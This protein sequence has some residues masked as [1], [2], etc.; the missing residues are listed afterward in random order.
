MTYQKPTYVDSSPRIAEPEFNQTTEYE[1]VIYNYFLDLV[2][3]DSSQIVVEKFKN[4]FLYFINDEESNSEALNALFRV[5][6]ENDEEKFHKLLNRCC[7]ILVNNWQSAR[8]Y[9]AIQNLIQ[10]FED[11]TLDYE[12]TSMSLER[13]R[14]WVKNFSQSQD[15]KELK[16]FTSR[17]DDGPWSHRY[18]S[19]LLTHQ[20]I[21]GKSKEQQEAARALSQQI[22]E[23]FKFD[24]AMYTAR[25]KSGGGDRT[26][27]TPTENPTQLGEDVLRLIKTVVTKRGAFS[28]INFANIFVNQTE[29]VSYKAFK[30]ALKKY[31]IFSV[32]H[33]GFVK[34]LNTQLSAK[35]NDLNTESESETLTEPLKQN[36]CQKV[37]EY[38][39]TEN[40]QE[41]SLLFVLLLNN[42]NPLTLAI[43]LLKIV[44]ICEKS[45]PH[46]EA[47]LASLIRYYEERT[48]SEC[49]WFIYFLEV[50]RITF[51]IY[52]DNVEY[53]VVKLDKPSCNNPSD[54]DE[55]E[56]RIFSFVKKRLQEKI[57]LMENGSNSNA[58]EENLPAESGNLA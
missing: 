51:A 12:T 28:Y 46:L 2:R 41:P 36:T 10:V 22:K 7:Y 14:A 56:Y 47:C 15:Y 27:A 16:L 32:E 31:L 33:Q 42:G 25:S 39:T 21:F 24:L 9:G 29:G 13:I 45:Y 50:V 57:A 4:L 55:E 49:R 1:Q 35:L 43:V 18:S 54:S 58:L 5:I 52:A 44:L 37:I 48:Q 34:T 38:L 53:T 40:Q 23:R 17:D 19:Y 30:Q 3:N 11:K 8:N 26:D 6:Y 20:Y